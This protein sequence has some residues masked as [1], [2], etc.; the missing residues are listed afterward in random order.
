MGKRIAPALRGRAEI[1]DL[2]ILLDPSPRLA[3]TEGGVGA[4]SNW[5]VMALN[6]QR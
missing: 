4:G 5:R 3:K 1:D 6:G 2:P